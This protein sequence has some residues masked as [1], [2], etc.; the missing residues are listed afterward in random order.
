[1]DKKEVLQDLARLLEEIDQLPLDSAERKRLHL[2][3]A[4]IEGHLEAPDESEGQAELV[5]TVD[6]LV[7]RL[8]ADHPAF[9]GILRRVM[10]ALGSMGV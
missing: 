8:E 4:D 10:N 5:D 7:T 3:V 2:M 6:Q 9:T 1:M